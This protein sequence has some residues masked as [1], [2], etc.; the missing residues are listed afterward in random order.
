M[1]LRFVAVVWLDAWKSSTDDVTLKTIDET[2]KPARME[3]R[4]W[5]LKQD[6]SGVQIANER[7]LD[8][9]DQSYRGRTYIPAGMLVSV[10]DFPKKRATRKKAPSAPVTAQPAG[11]TP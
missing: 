11:V 1:A 9:E 5:L 6:D 8:E 2:H 3:T 7:C 4:G 10:E